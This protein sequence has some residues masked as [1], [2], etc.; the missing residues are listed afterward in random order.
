MRP[1]HAYNRA[2]SRLPILTT[3]GLR[4]AEAAARAL[5][6][7]ERAGAA[8][9]GV[10]RDMVAGRPGRILVLAGPGNNGG[11]GFVVARQLREWFFDVDVAF[12]GLRERLP[13]DTQAAFDRYL[14]TGGTPMTDWE[15]GGEYALVVDALFGIGLRRPVEGAAARWIVAANASRAPVLAL[16]VPSG[17]DADTGRAGAVVIGAAHTATFIA[18]KPGLVTGDGIEC[19]GT[20][21]VHDLGLDPGR[22]APDCGWTSDWKHWATR[23]PARRR[24]AHKGDHGTVV[25]VGGATGMVGAPI[26][27]ARAAHHAGAGKVLVGFAADPA[28]AV[29]WIMPELMFRSAEAALAGGADAV[30]IGPGLGREGTPRWFAAALEVAAP[31]VLDAD[32]L[33]RIALDPDLARR[34]RGRQHPT[35]LTPHPAEA[36]RLLGCGTAAIQA[37]RVGQA[38]RIAAEFGAEVVLKGA[39]SVLAGRDGRW[40]IN[41]TG[42]AGLA[43]AGTGDVLAGLAVAML[44]RGLDASAALAAAVALHGAAADH[45]VN[46]GTGPIGL[47]ASELPAAA[48]MLLNAPT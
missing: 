1:S 4:S 34:V 3:A 20:L 35:V 10:A 36:G 25:I 9:A 7:M 8:A 44:A 41:T 23:L 17:L 11:D 31:L 48:R 37:D 33:N 21:S 22:S 19:A 18:L 30:L 46:A 32:A 38:R 40:A 39:G 29:D 12:A 16:D 14:P 47:A 15:G 2:M 45:L 13:A 43:S 28:P 26:L 5:P 42:N 24:G 6:L 27:A